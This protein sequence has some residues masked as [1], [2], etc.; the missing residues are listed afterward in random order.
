MMLREYQNQYS[1]KVADRL[2]AYCKLEGLDHMYIRSI[3]KRDKGH[4]KPG[5]AGRTL[6][7]LLRNLI[8]R[9]KPQGLINS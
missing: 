6:V 3:S 5:K 8:G 9:L 1:N 4:R 7:N 2:E